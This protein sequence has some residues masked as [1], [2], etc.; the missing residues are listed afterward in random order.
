[1]EFVDA[2]KVVLQREEKGWMG[3]KT[4]EFLKECFERNRVRDDTR[5][6][7]TALIDAHHMFIQE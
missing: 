1:M 5:I 3:K 4:R 6:K 7:A 2:R